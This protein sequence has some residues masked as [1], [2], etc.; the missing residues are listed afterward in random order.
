MGT[1]F[2]DFE[3]VIAEIS[4]IQQVI[5]SRAKLSSKLDYMHGLPSPTG[6]GTVPI[7]IAAARKFRDIAKRALKQDPALAARVDSQVVQRTLEHIFQQEILK[8]GRELS[9][10]LADKMVSRAVT[11]VRRNKLKTIKHFHAC[12]LPDDREAKQFA[13]GPVSFARTDVFLGRKEEQLRS[14]TK[15]VELHYLDQ[16]AKQLE[17]LRDR[18]KTDCSVCCGVIQAVDVEPS[19]AWPDGQDREE[20]PALPERPHG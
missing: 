18:L 19:D 17:G 6:I 15:G 7:G 16:S 5:K 10:S 13:V 9:Q 1:N 12:L 8:N 4:R 20:D 2:R 14:Y 11:H 3:F